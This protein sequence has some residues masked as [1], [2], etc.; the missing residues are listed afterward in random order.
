MNKIYQDYYNKKNNSINL[1]KEKGILSYINYN[2]IKKALRV[3]QNEHGINEEKYDKKKKEINEEL[4]NKINN[5][6]KG[7]K[8]SQN[9]SIETLNDLFFS[10]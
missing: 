5:S 10:L 9:D 2:E 3:T 7:N 6:T 8:S 4:N 1:L